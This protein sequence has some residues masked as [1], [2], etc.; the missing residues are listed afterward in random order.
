M[1]KDELIIK[2]EP[3]EYDNNNVKEIE[4]FLIE[5]KIPYTI[6]DKVYGMFIIRDIKGNDIELRYVSSEHYPMDNS[7]RFGEEYKGIPNDYFIKI[8]TKNIEENNIRTIWIFDF[9]MKQHSDVIDMDGNVIKDYRRQ[10]E[11]IKNTIRTATGHIF[12]R[13]YARDCEVCE[14]GNQEM[15]QFLELNCFYGHRVANVKLGLRLKKDKHGFKKGTLLFVYTFGNGYY[16][17]KNKRENPEIEIIRVSTT[18][19]CQVIGGA[20]KCLKHFLI[21]YPTM[22]ISGRQVEVDTLLYYCDSSHNDGRAMS[23][24]GFDFV[25]WAEG[26]CGFMNV[27]LQDVDEI[28]ERED[29]RKIH[30]KGNKGDIQHRKPLAHKRIMQLIKS[31]CIISVANAGT[32][33]YTINRK[34]YLKRFADVTVE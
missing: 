12:Y 20:S 16:A 29:G 24:M 26:G 25:S 30:I 3:S 23:T 9:E 4:D 2:F 19:G 31:R 10:W 22:E 11:V 17:N 5:M 33:V 15:K 34:E 32:S 14:I 7:K 21:N 18:I 28:Y 6:S 13:F 1:I 8:S 27:F